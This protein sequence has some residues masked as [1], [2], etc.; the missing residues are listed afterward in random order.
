MPSL[1]SSSTSNVNEAHSSLKNE[2]PA[3]YYRLNFI[4]LIR[5]V[6]DIYHDVLNDEEI[7]FFK[8][9]DSLSGD[10]QKLYVR[11]LTRKGQIFRE[12]K[13]QYDEISST[14]HAATELENSGLIRFLHEFRLEDIFSL[15]TKNEWLELLKNEGIIPPKSIKK[16]ELHDVVLEV[17]NER[18][19]T[20][21]TA[22]FSLL[23]EDQFTSFRLLFFG[24]LYSSLTDFLL[25]DLGL[26]RYENYRLNSSNRFFND[27][28]S[29]DSH[30]S[31]YAS[32]ES[33]EEVLLKGEEEILAFNLALPN[34][35][36][37][38][39]ALERRLCRTWLVLGRQLERLQC[40]DSAISI[41]N[42]ANNSA[43][44][45][46]VARILEKQQNSE[47]CL[48]LCLSMYQNPTNDEEYYFAAQFGARI[49]KKNGVTFPKAPVYTPPQS[50]LILATEDEHNV[51]LVAN[52]HF[53]RTSV[54]FYCENSL[55]CTVFSLVYWD[56]I[57][58][59]VASAFTHPFQSKPHDLYDSE[60]LERRH[61]EYSKAQQLMQ[62][63][64]L[65]RSAVKSKWEEKHGLSCSL[66]Y[67]QYMPWELVE[68]A[69]SRIPLQH[70]QAIFERMWSDLKNNR[71]GFP[72][73]IVFNEND[74]R[75][76]EIKGPGDRLQKN[77][78]RW[79]HFF[80]ENAIPHEVVNIEWA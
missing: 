52:A 30:L 28:A 4:K 20:F 1:S 80:H 33:I 32:I 38:D 67:W 53:N 59:P 40:L 31:Y 48:A 71:N 50:T 75:L 19:P 10:A 45:E 51:E 55:F 46:R 12:D 26:I 56:V 78:H 23:G 22:I 9:V 14:K 7:H 13:L 16:P 3:D 2:L 42:Q 29:I 44:R 64:A 73:L 27:R 43:S 61:A 11:M 70:W 76:V 41:Y 18:Q 66:C 21:D 34:K 24:N 15:F 5:H 49:A 63:E 25:S 54:S 72:D 68:L 62:N 17:F 39:A 58:A 6:F 37:G 79:M 65:F 8:T 57:F 47:A 74:Y 60:F 77:Q 69:I 36:E 35:I